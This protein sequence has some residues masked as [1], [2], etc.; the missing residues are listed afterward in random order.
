M[1]RDIIVSV[2]AFAGITGLLAE[3]FYLMQIEDYWM[4]LLMVSGIIGFLFTLGMMASGGSSKGFNT[5]N[6]QNRSKSSQGYNAGLQMQVAYQ[7]TKEDGQEFPKGGS[8]I[9][10]PQLVSLAVYVIVFV[11]GILL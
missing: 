2:I 10:I 8:T 3:V 9:N 4:N 5:V 7:A 11:I 6:T 1:K